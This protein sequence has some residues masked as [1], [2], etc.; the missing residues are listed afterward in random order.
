MITRMSAKGQLTIPAELRGTSGFDEGAPVDIISVEGGLLLRP[1]L[2]AKT[3]ELLHR[4][5]ERELRIDLTNPQ[6]DPR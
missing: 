3:V 2:S 4:A 1:Q 6:G 5:Y